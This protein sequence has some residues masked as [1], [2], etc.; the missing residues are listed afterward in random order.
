MKNYLSF[1]SWKQF[2]ICEERALALENSTWKF[3]QT[4]AM[5]VSA[6]F[7]ACVIGSSEEL[8]QFLTDNPSIVNSRTGE[9]KTAFKHIQYVA[10]VA[11]KDE[12]FMAFME[13]EY[14]HELEG[15][16]E[17]VTIVGKADIISDSKIVDVKAVV[18]FARAWNPA[19]RRK[20]TFIEQR[21]YATQG[22]IYQELYFQKTGVKLPFYLAATTKET[23][24]AR[25]IAT[26]EQHTLDLA[27][28]QFKE[29]VPRIMAIRRGE[30]EPVGCGNCDYCR[31]NHN[32]KIIDQKYIGMTDE[33]IRA[34]ME[35]NEDH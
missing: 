33:E 32:A 26:F 22:A 11:R 2:K 12:V 4:D 29:D 31:V 28:E 13:G 6:L 17:G 14:Q 5:L 27:L 10:E 15:T 25:A 30:V 23:A 24:P 34:D 9:L 16:I 18:N 8:E 19:K 35:Y 1:S 7:E 21:D 3:E 20:E